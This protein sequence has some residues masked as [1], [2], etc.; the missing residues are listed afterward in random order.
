MVGN[1]IFVLISTV[2]HL[3]P[4]NRL[5]A[6]TRYFRVQCNLL[7]MFITLFHQS[8]YRIA[9]KAFS[10]MDGDQSVAFKTTVPFILFNCES[11]NP[12]LTYTI[13][14]LLYTHTIIFSVPDIHPVDPAAGVLIAGGTKF[15]SS[16]PRQ[17]VIDP[18]T[19]SE[20]IGT[21]SV[22]GPAAGTSASVQIIYKGEIPAADSTIHTAWS[23]QLLRPWVD[24]IHILFFHNQACLPVHLDPEQ[25]SY[26]YQSENIHQFPWRV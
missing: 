1:I 25:T 21:L 24:F 26:R 16:V 22:P 15:G 5:S 4:A 13:Q 19:F 8:G 11:F 23:D 20:Q 17:I 6:G 9:V 14:I 7:I 2:L 18:E 3:P 12:D 10:V